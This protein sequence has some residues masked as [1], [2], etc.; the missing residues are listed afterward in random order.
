MKYILQQLTT[1]FKAHKLRYAIVFIFMVIASA[2]Y[3]API[4]ILRLFIDAL[5]QDDFTMAILI[6]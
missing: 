6:R 4:Y 3:V 5:I 2:M 1:Y